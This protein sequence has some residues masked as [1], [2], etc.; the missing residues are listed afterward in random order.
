MFGN[1]RENIDVEL[2][3]AERTS[4]DK[5][6]NWL[7]NRVSFTIR[8]GICCFEFMDRVCLRQQN[9]NPDIG[10]GRRGSHEVGEW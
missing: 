5:E 3:A 10:W 7:N 4:D 1:S 8:F 2:C 9:A 6:L